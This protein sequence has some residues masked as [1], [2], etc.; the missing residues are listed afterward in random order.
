MGFLISGFIVMVVVTIILNLIAGPQPGDLGYKDKG[1]DK[2]P[3]D[4]EKKKE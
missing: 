4:S 1:Y 3:S 2:K